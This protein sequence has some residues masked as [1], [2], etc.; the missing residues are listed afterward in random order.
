VGD[1]GEGN[2]SVAAESIIGSLKERSDDSQA[3]RVLNMLKTN[4]EIEKYRAEKEKAEQ[5][6]AK[7]RIDRTIAPKSL[8]LQYFTALLTPL[9]PLAS[10]LAVMA[11]VYNTDQTNKQTRQLDH[12][13]V[14][15]AQWDD[16]A[17]KFDNNSADALY[18]TPTF[19]LELS[20]W[21]AVPA[22]KKKVLF[23]SKALL[24]RISTYDAFIDVWKLLYEPLS[25]ETFKDVVAIDKAHAETYDKV[26]DQC[27]KFKLPAAL[28]AIRPVSGFWGICDPSSVNRRDLDDALGDAPDHESILAAYDRTVDELRILDFASDKIAKFLKDQSPVGNPKAYDVSF[29]TFRSANLDNVDFSKIKTDLT[30]FFIS[31]VKGA[32]LTASPPNRFTNDF[33]ETDWWDAAKI[34]QAA[35][36]DLVDSSYPGSTSNP[37]FDSLTISKPDYLAKVKG[38]CTSQLPACSSDKLKYGPEKNP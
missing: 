29:V 32:V 1:R 23:L 19:M 2:P 33:I 30:R 10:I 15:R 28:R 37:T 8:R 16:Y 4:A 31:S 14:E 25:D 13:K 26:I 5:D 27:R 22:Y 21:A 17:K 35:L 20:G 11:T 36:S 18:R 24:S 7:A 12:D 38:L 6:A 9:V 3:E 34:D